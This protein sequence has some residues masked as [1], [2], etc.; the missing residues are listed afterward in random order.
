MEFF[1]INLC[2]FFGT[3]VLRSLMVVDIFGTHEITC[4]LSPLPMYM[5]IYKQNTFFLKVTVLTRGSFSWDARCRKVAG[6][7]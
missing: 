2:V 3:A 4:A 5:Y 6:I 7:D 1:F